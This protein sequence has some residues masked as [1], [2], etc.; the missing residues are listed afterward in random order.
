MLQRSRSVHNFSNHIMHEHSCTSIVS[1]ARNSVK[2]LASA[3][4]MLT[5]LAVLVGPVAPAVIASDWDGVSGNWSSDLSPGWNATGVPNAQGATANNALTSFTNVVTTQDVAAGVTVGTLSLGGA[6]DN[7]WQLTLT[8]PLIL[9]QDGGGAGFATISNSDS[10]AGAVNALIVGSVATQTV[11]LADNLLVSNTSSSTAVNGAVQIIPKITGTGNVTFHSDAAIGTPTITSFPGAIRLQNGST[12]STFL[13]SVLVEKGLVAYNSATSFGNSANVITLGAAGM[14]DAMMLPTASVSVASPLVVAAGAGTLTVGSPNDASFTPFSTTSSITLNGNLT[15]RS[16]TASL[17]TTQTYA[18]PISGAGGLT[19]TG[20]AVASLSGT[21]TYGG[22]TTVS[23]GTLQLTKELALYNGTDTS[24]TDTNITVQ[25]L[26]SLLLNIGSAG[27]FSDAHVAQINALGSATGGFQPGSFLGLNPTVTAFAGYTYPNAITNSN[28]GANSV[29]LA[30]FG[31]NRL[32]TG[33]ANTYSGPTIVL[34]GTLQFANRNALYSANTANWTDTNLI[35]GAGTIA[36]FNVGGAGEFTAADIQ[37]ISGLGTATGGFLG[38]ATAAAGGAI[39]G[40]DTTN[41]AGGEFVYG[42]VIADL[43]GDANRIGVR[44]VGTGTLTLSGNNTYTG[45][46]VVNSGGT[47]K[48]TGTHTVTPASFNSETGSYLIGSLAS[49][50]GNVI[51]ENATIVSNFGFMVGN[52]GTGTATMT[53]GSLQLKAAGTGTGHF[54]GVGRN[55]G[56]TGTFTLNSGDIVVNADW[57]VLGVSGTG[58]GTQNGGNVSSL[59]FALGQNATG[60][61][62]YTFNDGTITTTAQLHNGIAGKGTFTQNGGT[63][64]L[65]TFMTNGESAAPWGHLS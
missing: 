59:T 33:A 37:Q 56:S 15:I 18:A 44:Q 26:G 45:Q 3:A 32:I 42:N 31:A 63:I 60:V 52:S 48:V 14:G 27:E 51:L 30:K 25:P 12:A 65:G 40:F 61:A 5:L 55:A 7:S 21:N 8:N 49:T 39:L 50:S 20:S 22:T 41:A 35:V 9:D 16:G 46:T 11:T 43:N 29:G 24:W 13:G 19:K 34:G 64:N 4:P 53:G 2:L 10:N 38:G 17:T 54:F 57:Y 6:N 36:A 58:H 62:D 1:G 23:Q 47:I 28:T